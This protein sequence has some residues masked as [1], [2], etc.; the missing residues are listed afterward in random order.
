MIIRPTTTS[1]VVIRLV[2]IR[3][4]A[5]MPG[6]RILPVRRTKPR[7]LSAADRRVR[8]AREAVAVVIAIV[9]ARVRIS[10]LRPI[11]QPLKVN[12][13]RIALPTMPA[14]RARMRNPVVS[15]GLDRIVSQ[16]RIKIHRQAGIQIPMRVQRSAEIPA[17]KTGPM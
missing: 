6:G 5:R 8:V 16:Q 11:K 7:S 2:I 12:L 14:I 3:P 9:N 17:R 15:A 1:P 13:R 4:K 10:Q